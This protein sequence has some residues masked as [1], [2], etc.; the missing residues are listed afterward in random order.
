M[1]TGL[2]ESAWLRKGIKQGISRRHSKGL[3]C[4]EERDLLSLIEIS[5]FPVDAELGKEGAEAC[6]EDWAKANFVRHGGSW[7]E[8]TR[9]RGVEFEV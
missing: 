8:G 1:D 6:P 7:A 5:V 9:L 3:S 2:T 4:V